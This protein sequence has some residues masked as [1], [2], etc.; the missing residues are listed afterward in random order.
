[1]L[2]FNSKMTRINVLLQSRNIQLFGR[3]RL[4]EIRF[5]TPRMQKQCEQG[6]ITLANSRTVPVT[7]AFHLTLRCINIPPLII[8]LNLEHV[9]FSAPGTEYRAPD[10]QFF[11][12]SIILVIKNNVVKNLKEIVLFRSI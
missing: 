3:K 7:P 1:M 12:Q 11:A 6:Y 2:Y 10:Y 5:Q 8:I 9:C 4:T